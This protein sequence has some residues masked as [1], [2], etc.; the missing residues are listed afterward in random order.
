MTP[1]PVKGVHEAALYV[2]DLD[3]AAT[4]YRDVLGFEEVGRDPTRHV[5]LRAGRDVLLLFDASATRKPGSA[6]PP[7]G[8]AGELHVAFEIAPETLDAWRDHFASMNVP[9][10]TE[11]TWP[12]G[13]TSLY[14]RDPDRHSVELVTRGIWGF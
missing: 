8:G 6:A 5:F 4:F 3:R 13:G 10:E 12:R 2:A 11:V 7:H 9:V 14:V 1:P